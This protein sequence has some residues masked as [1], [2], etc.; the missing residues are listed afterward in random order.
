MKFYKDD[1]LDRWYSGNNMWMIDHG[2]GEY[3]ILVKTNYG[4]WK[5][6]CSYRFTGSCR[7]TLEKCKEFVNLICDDRDYH[8]IRDKAKLIIK[9]EMS[10]KDIFSYL[11]LYNKNSAVK[12]CVLFENM[13]KEGLEFN[14][15]T[16]CKS[17]DEFV[18]YCFP[19]VD[20]IVNTLKTIKVVPDKEYEFH[21]S[22]QLGDKTIE[23]DMKFVLRIVHEYYGY[24]YEVASLLNKDG[25]I[26]E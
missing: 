6:V 12:Y 20:A 17:Y 11:E 19:Y 13:S 23:S 18:A 5:E 15:W 10:I 16:V 14:D 3:V 25:F 8:V 26:F 4:A 1:Y 7:E 24:S 22:Y 2:N 9:N 21:C